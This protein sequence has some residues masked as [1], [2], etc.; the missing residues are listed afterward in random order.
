[1]NETTF[2]RLDKI[3]AF[4]A[5]LCTVHCL[6][7]PF[8]ITILPLIGLG[9]LLEETTERVFIAV[10]ITVAAL[11]L[12]PTY[13]S[14]HRKFSPLLL[15]LGGVGLLILT[16]LLFEENRVLQAGFLI[17]GAVSLTAAHLLN[18]K[19]CRECA[20]CTSPANL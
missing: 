4:A 1:M 17:I 10:S 6:V 12:L 8:F 19:L 15:A 9:F 7:T 11:S 18:R 3:G 13:F 14:R 5:W 2:E 20:V 16:H